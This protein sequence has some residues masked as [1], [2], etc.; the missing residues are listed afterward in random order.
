MKYRL[1]LLACF[2]C[3][4]PF[5]ADLALVPEVPSAETDIW[6]NKPLYFVTEIRDLF[7]RQLVSMSDGLDSFI[8]SERATDEVNGSHLRIR[9]LNTL[10]QSGEIEPRF[11]TI[12]KLDLPKT[13]KRLS[14]V[15]ESTEEEDGEGNEREAAPRNFISENPEQRNATVNTAIQWVF[16]RNKDWDIRARLGGSFGGSIIRQ[17]TET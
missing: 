1:F 10:Y 8:G 4:T 5:A 14:L 9:Q 6:V 2:F 13:N 3:N 16:Q 15:I 7:S 17:I 11:G 12:F